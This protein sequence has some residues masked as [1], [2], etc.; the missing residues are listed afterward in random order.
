MTTLTERPRGAR[1]LPGPRAAAS[2][3]ARLRALLA[4][5]ALLAVALA[6][7]L[8]GAVVAGFGPRGTSGTVI[9]LLLVALLMADVAAL[10]LLAR[11]RHLGRVL[12]LAVSYMGF[13]ALALLLLQELGAFTGLDALGGTF[14]RG[15]P[16]LAVAVLA[17]VAGGVGERG[18]LPGPLARPARIVALVALAGMLVAVGLFPALWTLVQR[19]ADPVALGLLAAVAVFGFF[20]RMAWSERT[21]DDFATT[22]TQ[23]EGLDGLL[24]VSPNVLG[25]LLFFVG[26]LLFSLYASLTDWDLF[27]TPVFIGLDNYIQILS[28]D[29]ASG[30]ELREGFRE[31]LSIG[32]LSVGARDPLFWTSMRNIAL[33]AVLAIPLAV[34]PALLIASALNT[35]VPGMRI[36]RAIY[37][38]P[39]V[40]GVVGVTLIWKQLFNATVGYVNYGMSVVAGWFGATAP[41]PQW[42]SDADIVLFS[43]VIVFVWQYIGYNTILFLAG[44]Q[45]LPADL[46]EAAHLDGA[47]GWQRFRYITIP[48]LAPT[49]F[50]V[51]ATTGIFALQLFTESVILF[52]NFTPPGAGPNNAALTPVGYLYQEGFQRFSPGYASA[53]A[54]LLF[55]VI[56]A[57]TFVQFQRQRAAAEGV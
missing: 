48:Q 6:G 5:H 46:Y 32:G 50:F 57:F 36:F 1:R 38:V 31:V 27:S 3:P 25:F 15:V 33:F 41:Q 52:S 16:F 54:W 42:L 45:G 10:P 11:R 21:A 28:L 34:L 24:Y 4:W 30:G 44:M 39:T 2:G 12:S 22:S 56:F 35:K 13:L 17:F 53:V 19:L 23:R 18:D 14:I 8:V 7:L 29:V 55:F 43:L 47:S 26:P 51:V 20:A 9:G 37:F 40:A 49:T